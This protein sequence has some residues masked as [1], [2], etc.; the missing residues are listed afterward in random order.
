MNCK[1]KLK[2]RLNTDGIQEIETDSLCVAGDFNVA[3]EQTDNMAG[4]PHHEREVTTL[5][6]MLAKLDIH[7][8]WRTNHPVS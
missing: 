3:L 1:T 8:V 2:T 6:E 5:K 4:L 7:D